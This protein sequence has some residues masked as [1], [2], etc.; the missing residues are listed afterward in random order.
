MKRRKNQLNPKLAVAYLRVSTDD[1]SLGPQAQEA[2]I[3]RWAKA[4]G[5]ELVEVCTDVGVSGSLE[6]DKRP[7]LLAALGALDAARAGILVVA[8]RDRLARDV[9]VASAIERLVEARG[10]RIAAAD[11]TGNAT[12]PEGV[13]MR[14]LVDLFAQYERALIRAR[15]TA[16]LA[17]KRSRGER[18]G[19][20]P[21]G[22]QAGAGPQLE[23]NEREQTALTRIEE[24]RASGFAVRAIADA[25]NDEGVPA[26]GRRWHATTVSRLLDRTAV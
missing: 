15:T 22:Y 19:E 11:G 25:L 7:A 14:G 10:A 13:L 16:A 20:V 6:L 21:I 17:V 24:L 9:V 5:V 8:K 1:Q 4:E 18:V 3:R 12:G 2:A 23:V 26:R